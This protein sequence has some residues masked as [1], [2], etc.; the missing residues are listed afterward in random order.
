MTLNFEKKQEGSKIGKFFGFF[1]S[2][3]VFTT[4]L[5]FIL[6]ILDRLPES[7]SYFH[8]Y[9]LTTYIILIGLLTNKIIK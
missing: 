7:I 8:M 3:I 5:Y 4:I 9:I 6:K 2:Y 1:I